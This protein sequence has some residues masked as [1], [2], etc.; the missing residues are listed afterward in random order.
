MNKVHS[1]VVRLDR[2]LATLAWPPTQLSHLSAEHIE[3]FYESRKHVDNVRVDLS[4][5]RHLLALA[6]GVSDSAPGR[7]AQALP[8]QIKGE[9]RHSYSR[10]EF[11]RIADAARTDLRA[12]AA[13]IRANRELL[14]RFRDGDIVPGDDRLLARKLE[15]LDWADRF[16]D[17][18]RAAAPPPSASRRA[19]P[20]PKMWVSR[21]RKSVV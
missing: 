5:L 21:D 10:S 7:L 6:E 8:K 2:Y 14:R 15:L 12:A 13:R 17:V 4:E 1:V 20:R 16:A 3:G 19:R 11:K 9:G 18:P